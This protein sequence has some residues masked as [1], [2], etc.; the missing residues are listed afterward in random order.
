M[1]QGPVSPHVLIFPFP[2]QGHVNSMLKLAELLSV[3]GLHVTFLNSEYNQ[4]R[5]L[6]H[7]DIQTR[8]SRYPGFRFQTISD[9]LTTDH[10]RTGER[11]MDLFEGLKAT[12]KPIFRELVISRGQGSDTLPPVNCIIADGIMSFT[13]DI[14]NEV[15]IPIISFRTIS[16]CSFWAYFSALKLIESGELPLKGND[17]DQLVTSI[18]GMEGFLRKRD[19]PSLIRVSNL[20]NEGLLLVMKETQ[21]TPRAHALILNTFEDL[22][23]PILGQIRNHCPKTY[24]IGPLHAHL[25]TRLASESTTSVSSNSLRQEDRSCIAWL[26]RQPSKSVIYVSFGSLTVITRKQ[27]IEFCY[28]LVNSG[29]RFLWVIRTDSLAEEDGER[30]TPAELLEGAKERSYIV[31][32]APQEEVLAHPAVGGFLT[33]SGWNSTLESI[34][35]GVPM[36]CWPYFADQQ[37]NSRFVSHVWKLG[38]D[39]KD[40]CDRLIVEKMVRDLMEER[41]DELLK[42]ADMMATRARKCVSEGGSSYCNLSSLIEEIRLM[43]RLS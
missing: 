22:E 37:I 15:G 10:P 1:D 29:S 4:H 19:L 20:D 6:L 2:A 35:A 30:Q 17:M 40:T 9:G 3:A 33:H 38:S 21:Q 14:A 5:L 27:L 23:G 12:A 13:I 41:R 32:W 36:I 25:K 43:G 39:M 34:C 31:E 28:G 24:T 16:A 7:T 42:T 26:N 11:L 18:P 8:F